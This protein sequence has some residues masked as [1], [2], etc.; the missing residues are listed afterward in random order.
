MYVE[1]EKER[2]R[3]REKMLKILKMEESL[4]PVD[5]TENESINYLFLLFSREKCNRMETLG[6]ISDTN[7]VIYSMYLEMPWCDERKEQKDGHNGLTL[8][9]TLIVD[10]K[11]PRAVWPFSPS[12]NRHKW[13]LIE[14]SLRDVVRP[15]RE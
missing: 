5:S 1:K 12:V 3:E 7:E 15:F 13:P 11:F 8:V 4:L 6:K 10:F 2:E 14:T 9:S